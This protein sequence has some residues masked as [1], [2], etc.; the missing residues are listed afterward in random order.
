M[1]STTKLRES[2]IVLVLF[3]VSA[4][5][6]GHA[7]PHWVA[8]WAASQQL[9]EPRN[10]LPA[11]DLRDATLRQIVHLSLGGQQLRIYVS[12]RFGSAPLRVTSLHIAKPISPAS[13]GIV[14]G[15]DEAVSFSSSPDV[16]VPVGAEIVSDPVSF[17]AAALS[18]L[19]ITLHLDQGPTEQTGHP[20]SR[21]TSYLLRG[22]LVGAADLPN[23][24]KVEHWYFVSG[25]DVAAPAPAASLVALGDSITDGHGAT[26]DG[27]NRW[28]DVLAKRLQAAN[29]T[30]LVAVLNHGIGGNRLLLDGLGPNAVARFDHDVLT[31]AGVRYL[32]VLEGVNDL[33]M[34]TRNGEI[35]Q[36]EH[37]SLVRS[38][39][40]AYEQFTVRAHTHGI[41]V[42]GATILPFTGSQYYHP[43]PATEADRLAINAWIRAPGHFDAVVDFDKIMRDPEHPEKMLPAFDSG[44]HLHPSP[45]GYAAMAEAIPLSLFKTVATATGSLRIALTFDDLPAHGPLPPGETR[46]EVVSKILA[47]LRNAKVPAAYGFINGKRVEERPSD[48]AVFAAW[49]KAGYP[50]GNHTWSH[51]NLNEHQVEAFAADVRRNEQLLSKWMRREDWHWFRFPFLKEGDTR[52]KTIRAR[53]FLAQRGYKIASVT[54]SFGD[55]QWNEPYARCRAKGDEKAI[56]ELENSYLAAADAGIDYYQGLSQTLYGRDIPYVLLMHVGAFDAE[57]LPR[58]LKLYESRAVKFVTLAEAE[59]DEF[60]RRDINLHLPPGSGSLE[61]AMAERHLPLPPHLMPAPPPDRLCR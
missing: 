43:G 57:M 18:D 27:N 1:L 16:T 60:Y 14:S 12:N 2:L 45:A 50:L 13:A 5:K 46:I 55:Y 48:A 24:K 37:D 56:A 53:T 52:E 29:G 61:G 3:L 23:A 33:G 10:S 36:E 49:R 31:Q 4:G 25:V 54:M 51:M 21:A 47:A 19:A 22:D 42:F 35:S 15:T 58:L 32:V 8:S 40:A 34:S 7:Q 38:I 30:Q 59:R 9:A 26:T 17:P 6:L 41:Q 20:G 44:D 28:P 39:L 11:E